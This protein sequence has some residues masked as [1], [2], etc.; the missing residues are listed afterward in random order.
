MQEY[1]NYVFSIGL[2]NVM[3]LVKEA[4]K[5]GCN[6]MLYINGFYYEIKMG[7]EDNKQ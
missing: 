1:F 5:A 4:Q 7:N 6:A 3:D 2:E